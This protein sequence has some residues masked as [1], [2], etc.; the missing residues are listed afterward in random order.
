M[1][2]LIIILDD[3]T[4]VLGT[5]DVMTWLSPRSPLFFC[6][7]SSRTLTTRRF[8]FEISM[9]AVFIRGGVRVGLKLVEVRA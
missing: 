4:S 5:R 1:I 9:L 3:I 7:P 8:C 2:R 6:P